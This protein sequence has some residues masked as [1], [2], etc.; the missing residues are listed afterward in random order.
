MIIK[1]NE[2]WTTRNQAPLWK[3][4]IQAERYMNSMKP[5][6]IKKEADTNKLISQYSAITSDIKHVVTNIPKTIAKPAGDSTNYSYRI[7]YAWH[8]MKFHAK[9]INPENVCVN[10]HSYSQWVIK[11]MNKKWNSDA[12]STSISPFS[13]V[14]HNLE[15]RGKMR[16]FVSRT[17]LLHLLFAQLDGKQL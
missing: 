12:W 6:N 10:F 13:N 5:K 16:K 11:H 2:Q 4:S 17:Y 1:V 8:S 15:T 14:I 9:I 7:Y 3:F